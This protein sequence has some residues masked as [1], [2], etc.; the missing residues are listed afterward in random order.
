[1]PV[2]RLAGRDAL[3]ADDARVADVDHVRV[4]DVEADP[5]AEQ[6]D[7][8]AGQ[9]PDR[10]D[11]ARLRRPAGA[12][13]A[14]DHPSKQVEQRRVD[15]RHRREDVALV[16]V[17]ERDAERE[18]GDQIQVPQRQRSAE[19]GQP[20]QEGGAEPEPDREAV[21]LL[22]PE[23]AGRAARHLP[24]DLRACPGLDDLSGRVLDAAGRDL[25]D[26]V[27]GRPDLDLPVPVLLVVGRLSRPRFL[28]VVA[29]PARDLRVRDEDRGCALL[30]QLRV[31]RS[32]GGGN[33]QQRADRDDCR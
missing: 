11:R 19:V 18:Q 17:P 1:M 3:A 24:G 22:S 12:H 25:P 14:P 9:Q 8:R 6:E 15:D 21:D 26:A 2:R 5:E 29:Q 13:A 30:V 27:D 28:R 23:R 20:D 10:P 31:R 7:G 4:L 16:E 32:P 33:K